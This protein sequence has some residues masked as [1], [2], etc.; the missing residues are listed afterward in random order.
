[1]T[2]WS[3]SLITPVCTRRKQKTR[4]GCLKCHISRCKQ[5]TSHAPENHQ[6]D[7]SPS[8][9]LLYSCFRHSNRNDTMRRK[10]HSGQGLPLSLL[11]SFSRL[12]FFFSAPFHSSRS[13]AC[14][15]TTTAEALRPLRSL[16]RLVRGLIFSH[17]DSSAVEASG[18]RSSKPV[19][20][21]RGCPLSPSALQQLPNCRRKDYKKRI[22]EEP[23]ACPAKEARQ[24]SSCRPPPR[25][26]YISA[27]PLTGGKKN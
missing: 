19:F 11:F 25:T 3:K 10:V 5:R 27:F 15:H 13:S 16:D 9:F 22:E 1:M 8:A 20:E 24:Y 12:F 4:G 18:S 7:T 2:Y 6:P 23:S 21:T 17:L 14:A 26:A